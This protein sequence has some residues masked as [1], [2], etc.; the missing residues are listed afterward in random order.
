MDL[1]KLEMQMK[2]PPPL[3]WIWFIFKL[4]KKKKNKIKRV[5]TERK[6]F[7]IIRAF[8]GSVRVVIETINW[9][10]FCVRQGLL[11]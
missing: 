9:Y 1:I 11:K 2:L 6:F 8:K 10:C 7:F 3:V 4:E 5:K